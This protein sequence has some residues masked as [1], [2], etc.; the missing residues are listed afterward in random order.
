M[1]FRNTTETRETVEQLE[2]REIARR[3]GQ[4]L[5]LRGSWEARERT[6][7]ERDEQARRDAIRRDCAMVYGEEV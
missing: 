5:I 4:E 3:L 7:A 6:R 2:R 1:K